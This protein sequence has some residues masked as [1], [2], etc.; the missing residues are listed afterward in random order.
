[1]YYAL[2]VLVL[3]IAAGLRIW[4]LSSLPAGFSDLELSHIDVALDEIQRGD[5]RVFY[6]REV[7]GT[8]SEEVIG[9]EGLY[10]LVLAATVI[11]FGTGTFGLRFVSLLIGM[12]TIAL[13]YA[14]AT[15]LFTYRVG[16]ITSAFYAVLMFPI[17]LSRLVVVETALPLM[18]VAIMLSMVRALPVYN[19]NRAET[20]N[21]L[22]YAIMA[23]LISMSLYLHQSSLFIVLMAMAFIVYIL[24]ENRPMSM[25]RLS[26]IG[27]AIL[28][29]L[30]FSMPYLLSTF[31]LPELG[32][33]GRIVG[34]Y[35]GIINSSIASTLGLMI[36]GDANPLYNLPQRPLMDIISGVILIFGFTHSIR[37][38]RNPS[39]AIIL[40]AI[41]FLG[42][43]AILA[44]NSPNFLAMSVVLPIVALLL[45]VGA[46]QIIQLVPPNI[47]WLAIGFVIILWT[48]N[49]GWTV[50][51]LYNR[52][53]NNTEVQ[54]VYNSDI[55]QIA[56]HFDRT[57][58]E[59][60]VIICNPDWNIS[61]ARNE[62][63]SD[64]ELIKLHMNRDTALLREVDC[65][66]GFIFVN[67]GLH[68][69]VLLIDPMQA[70][71]L[72]PLVVD[73][74]A[75]G[76]PVEGLPD[77][78]VIEMQVQSELED[79][80]GVFTTTS[81]A[82]Y[83]TEADIS[84]RVPVAP[85]IRFGGNITWLGYE[86]EPLAE[87]QADTIVPVVT[88]WRIEGLVP[89]D[90][91]VFTHV[92][93]DPIFPAAQVDTI[94][95]DPTQLRERDIYLH[96]ANIQLQP[97][98]ETGEYVISVGAYQSTSDERLPVFIDES[99]TQGNRIFLYQITIDSP[100]NTED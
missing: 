58:H 29:L 5:I 38:W 92:L 11:P 51:S 83:A 24:L 74:L 25:R 87:Y 88:Y 37:N 80:L 20:S 12:I 50:D 21:T 100:D 34:Q 54:L 84:A 7:P 82:S 64:V 86:N 98:I 56:G 30:I 23:F 35:D 27:F 52:W 65:R 60:P 91:L 85:P 76:T 28:L 78:T 45:G 63:Y 67:A 96:N 10:P 16:L 6:E 22:A 75:L 47:K 13:I 90:L 77:N 32:A 2:A 36:Q 61:R 33:N 3:L 79:A 46:G 94:Y 40:I 71:E 66:D 49:L 31:R 72:S 9:Q 8:N 89:S 93:S 68:Q 81:P 43:P 62:P 70:E 73:W 44:D 1:M 95:I 4:N 14:L 57:A 48:G 18:I 19:R 97:T 99:A 59:I 26:Y 42:P 69:Q 41:I 39:Y 15:R 17:L 53:A 55:G